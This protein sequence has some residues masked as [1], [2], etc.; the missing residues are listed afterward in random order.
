MGGLSG[1]TL[2]DS[3]TCCSPSVLALLPPQCFSAIKDDTRS[4]NYLPIRPEMKLK[5]WEA[6]PEAAC[7]SLALHSAGLNHAGWCL[8]EDLSVIKPR[9]HKHGVTLRLLRGSRSDVRGCNRRPVITASACM[10]CSRVRL[11]VYVI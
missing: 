6:E 3:S 1:S 2:S 8:Y 4:G 9:I 7:Y 10:M 11:W 5:Q